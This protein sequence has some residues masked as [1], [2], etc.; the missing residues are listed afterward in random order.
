MR[1]SGIPLASEK[2]AAAERPHKVHIHLEGAVPFVQSCAAVS[3]H[4]HTV[5]RGKSKQAGFV[6]EHDPFDRSMLIL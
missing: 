3:Q 6:A 1:T 5:L 2:A 4:Q